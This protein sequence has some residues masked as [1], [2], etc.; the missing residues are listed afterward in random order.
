MTAVQ[1]LCE[2]E[3]GSGRQEEVWG[4]GAASPQFSCGWSHWE[5]HSLPSQPGTQAPCHH[6]GPPPTPLPAHALA[7]ARMNLHGS[8]YSCGLP[9]TVHAQHD[10]V[11]GWSAADQLC[12]L[13]LI[14]M[15]FSIGHF[16]MHVWV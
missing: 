16:A 8:K 4:G 5:G 1:G 6:G 15:S 12:M 10:Q 3:R 14:F 13:E 7:Q 11:P 2:N 9:H